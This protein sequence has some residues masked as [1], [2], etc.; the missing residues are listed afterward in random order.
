MTAELSTD[1]LS[2]YWPYTMAPKQVHTEGPWKMG[3][4]AGGSMVI[5]PTKEPF[6]DSLHLI[7]AFQG[8]KEQLERFHGTFCRLGYE[9]D[10]QHKHQNENTWLFNW[11][12]GSLAQIYIAGQVAKKLFDGEYDEAWAVGRA[13]R[14]AIQEAEDGAAVDG[15]ARAAG[16]SK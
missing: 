15:Q 10:P 4:S 13:F 3:M 12:S 2:T 16:A 6:P 11:N 5:W 1:R 8:T 9:K 14:D 7:E